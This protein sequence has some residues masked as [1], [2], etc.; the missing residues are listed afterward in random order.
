MK[1]IAIYC[2]AR[3][4]GTPRLVVCFVASR[5]AL[6][7]LLRIEVDKLMDE[8]EEIDTIEIGDS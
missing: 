4:D 5:E 8:G 7:T 3:G 2:Q 1:S 6:G